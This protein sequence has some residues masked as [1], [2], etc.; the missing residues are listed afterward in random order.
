VH[1]TLSIGVG[2]APQ[3][4]PLDELLRAADLALYR[5]K[6]SGRDAVAGKLVGADPPTP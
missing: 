6:A 2:A 4:A 5:A 1:V 3:G